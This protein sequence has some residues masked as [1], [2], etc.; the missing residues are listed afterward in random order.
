MGLFSFFTGKSKKISAL[1]QEGAVV[2]DVRTAG[3]YKS[4]HVKG[5]KNIP[6]NQVA[7]QMAALQKLNKPLVFCCASGMRSG[8]AASMAKSKG[9]NCI[10]GGSWSSV[11][12]AQ[13][14][15]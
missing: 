7:S 4:G 3:E 5:S 11:A 10:N 15:S 1:L 9:L 8:Q 14:A 12:R 6:L 2:V 13:K